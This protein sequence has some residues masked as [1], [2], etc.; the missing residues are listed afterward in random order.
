VAAWVGWCEGISVIIQQTNWHD[1]IFRYNAILRTSIGI[2]RI[3]QKPAM[4]EWHNKTY[5]YI[6]SYWIIATLKI[7]PIQRSLFLLEGWKY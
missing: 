1:E 2:N 7:T 3:V 6:I 5:R 4:I